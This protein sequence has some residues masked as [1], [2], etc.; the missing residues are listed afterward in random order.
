MIVIIVISKS[1]TLVS[2]VGG[3]RG[4]TV[5]VKVC[6]FFETAK[7]FANKTFVKYPVLNEDYTLFVKIWLL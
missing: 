1:P 5:T 3:K 4:V 6:I 2:C 7:L